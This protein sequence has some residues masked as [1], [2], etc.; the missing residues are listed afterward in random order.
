MDVFSPG[1]TVDTAAGRREV[2]ARASHY[3]NGQKMIVFTSQRTMQRYFCPPNLLRQSF[4]LPPQFNPGPMPPRG[5][6]SQHP[7]LPGK[8]IGHAAYYLDG[9]SHILFKC[10]IGPCLI[11]PATLWWA[12]F[13]REED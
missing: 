1:D 4:D 12:E 9:E 2:D 8:V 13:V 7:V 3:G 11:I 10:D 5:A 6:L